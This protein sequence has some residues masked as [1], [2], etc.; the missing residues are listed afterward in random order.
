MDGVKWTAIASTGAL[1]PLEAQLAAER[2]KIISE[3]AAG[4]SSR[5]TLVI[6]LRLAPM[7]GTSYGNTLYLVEL[8]RREF[9]PEHKPAT[10]SA[11]PMADNAAAMGT[12]MVGL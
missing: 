7:D 6:A 8:V 4:L 11:F 9:T 3:Q 5:S 2:Q 12:P 1:V 10:S